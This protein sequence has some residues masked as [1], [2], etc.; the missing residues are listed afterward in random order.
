MQRAHQPIPPRKCVRVVVHE[1]AVVLIVKA[2]AKHGPGPPGCRGSEVFVSGVPNHSGDLIVD[3]VQNQNCGRERQ[4][5]GS[6]QKE[7][8]LYKRADEAVTVV[9]PG[10]WN[11]AFVVQR[12][13]SVKQV[14]VHHAVAPV[15]PAVVYHQRSQ[16]TEGAR[17]PA[18][19][20]RF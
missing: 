18:E 8:L 2:R 14:G 11:D 10:S 19:L 1:V 3:F 4:K 6:E 20:E 5:E 7:G 15:E 13:K 16:E 9:R 17:T 12:V